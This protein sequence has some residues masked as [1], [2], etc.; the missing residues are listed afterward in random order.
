M[1]FACSPR[2]ISHTQNTWFFRISIMLTCRP[3]H[4]HI[5]N[6]C[7]KT[8]QCLKVFDIICSNSV[9]LLKKNWT[10]FPDGTFKVEVVIQHIL[11]YFPLL[12]DKRKYSKVMVFRNIKHTFVIIW[13]YNFTNIFNPCVEHIWKVISSSHTNYAF[14]F[15][16]TIV[17]HY[18]PLPYHRKEK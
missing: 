9:S 14:Y 13:G 12:E 1:A 17:L 4:Q 6:M 7:W 16:K 10:R 5:S 15:S 11:P 18:F 3:I 2:R 8:Y